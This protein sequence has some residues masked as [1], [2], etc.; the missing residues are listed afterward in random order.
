MGKTVLKVLVSEKVCVKCNVL[1]PASDFSNNKAR[2]CDGL[3]TWCKECRNKKRAEWA[4]K[5]RD[6]IR[7][8]DRKF[9]QRPD[10]RLIK[11]QA[12]WKS[13]G[14]KNADGTWFKWHDYNVLLAQQNGRCAI[15]G[16]AEIKSKTS[17]NLHIDH[18]HSNGIVR[19]LLCNFCNPMLGYS[20]DNPS[21]LRKAAQMLEE[22]QRG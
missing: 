2:K 12:K 21:I 20:R 19:W 17:K 4:L 10:I 16:T 22:K 6:K 11:T 7:A 3:T 15:C 1:K 8:Y 9:S 14:Y 18:D 13:S 5:N